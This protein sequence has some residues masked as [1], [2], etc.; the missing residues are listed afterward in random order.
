VCNIEY[1]L[2]KNYEF[3]YIEGEI[4]C[5]CFLINDHALNINR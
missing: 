5:G 2:K 4:R 1:I 3:L